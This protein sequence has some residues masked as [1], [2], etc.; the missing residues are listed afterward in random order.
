MWLYINLNR[1]KEIKIY[2][3]NIHLYNRQSGDDSEA[4]MYQSSSIERLDSTTSDPNRSIVADNP[5]IVIMLNDTRNHFEACG[6][7]GQKSYL[8]AAHSTSYSDNAN[9]DCVDAVKKMLKQTDNQNKQISY[10]LT[11]IIKI[12]HELTNSRTHSRTN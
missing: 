3:I 9:D 2:S 12:T 6:F 5:C 1:I 4:E 11:M 7:M 10:Q 8:L